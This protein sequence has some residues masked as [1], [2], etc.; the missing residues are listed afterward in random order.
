M[1]PD[2]ERRAIDSRI[3]Q[4]GAAAASVRPLFERP[5]KPSRAK[6]ARF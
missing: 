6:T 5:D 1:N 4:A 2:A 3:P